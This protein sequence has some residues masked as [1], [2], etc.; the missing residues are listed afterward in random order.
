MDN[1][2]TNAG[3]CNDWTTGTSP[4][5]IPSVLGSKKTHYPDNGSNI[6]TSCGNNG[7]LSLGSNQ[8]N[9]TDNVHIRANLCAATACNPIFKNTTSNT[10]YM[11]IEGSVNF[12]SLNTAAGSGP[13]VMIVYGADPSSKVSVCPYGGALY[14]GNTNNTSAP[15]MYLLANNGVC[16]DKT[17]FST[18]P[19]LGGLSGK[20]IYIATNPGTPFDL[21]LNNQFD[22]S[23]VP[24]NLAW[25]AARYRRL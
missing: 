22:S 25:R 13:I 16:L 2:Y 15:V 17:K 6:S 4:L 23:K 8:Y 11:F 12:A 10:L 1:T 20:N 24:I 21:N 19:A 9:L 18:S 14:L 5:Q 7:D 3:S